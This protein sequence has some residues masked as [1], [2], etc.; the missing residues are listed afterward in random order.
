MIKNPVGRPKKPAGQI[1]ISKGYSLSPANYNF[2][3]EISKRQQ[4]KASS[5]LNSLLDNIRNLRGE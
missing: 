5:V 4:K 1:S 3:A 2:I